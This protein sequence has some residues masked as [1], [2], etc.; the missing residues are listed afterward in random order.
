[1]GGGPVRWGLV[2]RA[3]SILARP[4]EIRASG[5]MRRLGLTASRDVVPLVPFA[6]PLSGSEL[7]ARLL[8][9]SPRLFAGPWT[10]WP[11]LTPS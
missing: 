1:M 7:E 3:G 8:Q 4:A 9:H 6:D 5:F 11:P 2:T 10:D